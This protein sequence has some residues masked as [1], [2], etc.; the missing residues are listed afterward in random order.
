MQRLRWRLDYCRSLLNNEVK[1]VSTHTMKNK[2]IGIILALLVIG[3]AGVWLVNRYSESES[4]LPPVSDQELTEVSKRAD[5]RAEPPTSAAVTV[6]PSQRVRLAVGSLGFADD[7]ANRQLGDLVVAGLSSVGNLELVERTSLDRALR[8]AEMSLSGLVRPKEAIRVGKLVRADWF[9]LGNTVKVNGTNITVARVVDA[10]NGLMRDVRASTTSQPTKMAD[11][12]AGFVRECRAAAT[13]PKPQVYLAIGAFA[14]VG[15]NSRQA[16]FP[17][18]LRA[19][20][21]RTLPSANLTL[22]ERE[23]VT[24]IL[25]EVRL[26]L[27]GLTESSETN[28]PVKMQSA[29]WLVDGSFQS[30]ETTGFE[31]EVSLRVTRIFGRSTTPQILRGPPGEKLYDEIGSVVRGTLT[32]ASAEAL[33]PT[34][35]SE[36]REQLARGKELFKF[37]TGADDPALFAWHGLNNVASRHQSPDQRRRNL[38]EAAR[39]LEAALL[40]DPTNGETRLYLGASLAD[41]TMSHPEKGLDVLRELAADTQQKRWAMSAGQA[42]GYYYYDANPAEA[43]KWMNVAAANATTERG[44]NQ[45]KEKAAELL[46]KASAGDIEGQRASSEPKTD[47]QEQATLKLLEKRIESAR[48]VMLGKGGVIDDRYGLEPY[49]DSFGEDNKKLAAK[50]LEELLPKLQ[51]R[52]PDMKA[53][54][55][56]AAVSFQVDTNAPMIAEYGKTVSSWGELPEELLDAKGFFN[57]LQSTVYPWCMKFRRFDLALATITA[58]RRAA[59]IRPEVVFTDQDKIRLTYA[60]TKLGRWQEGLEVVETLGDEPV[61]MNGDGPWGGYFD[62]V[63]PNKIANAIRQ[64]INLPIADNGRLEFPHEHKICV[65]YNGAFAIG[66]DAV[67]LAR[68]GQ[69]IKLGFDGRTNDLSKLPIDAWQKISSVEVTGDTVWVGTSGA[70]LIEFD[71]KNKQSRLWTVAEGLLMNEISCLASDAGNLWIGSGRVEGLSARGRSTTPGGLTRMDLKTKKVSSY[72]PSLKTGANAQFTEPPGSI[73]HSL[74][75]GQGLV[76]MDAGDFR[77]YEPRVNAWSKLSADGFSPSKVIFAG[78]QVVAGT[79]IPQCEVTLKPNRETPSTAKDKFVKKQV[80]CAE[81]ERMT[82]DPEISPLIMGKGINAFPAKGG[83][84]VSS[85]AGKTFDSFLSAGEIP[86]PPT[87]LASDGS[88]LYVAGDN[89]IATVDMKQRKLLKTVL[90]SEREVYDLQIA[91]G[92]LWALMYRHLYGAPLSALQ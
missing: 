47:G 3:G 22:L 71:S 55:L 51:Q 65:H 18:Q 54:L 61:K 42:L 24:A 30:Y 12:L 67:W 1:L 44:A 70:G 38:E 84:A 66:P 89:Y 64:R 19:H 57:R 16:Q 20:L 78:D 15:V 26:D 35:R 72:T 41:E 83:L 46:L 31:V 75:A 56:G 86:S 43:A 17:S 87:A 29:F 91:G 60:F 79:R 23:L 59:E 10:R 36:A 90:T 33:V 7:Q 80:S 6:A 73:L 48:S 25:D 69:L 74:V 76:L 81:L 14:D 28:A 52:Y 63:L 62:V 88:H 40:L 8:E 9:L 82:S 32:K 2:I 77:R 39:A 85:N 4:T 27:A 49:V 5:N 11:E 68:E 34:R 53:H 37:T 92:K 13:T 50:R 21:T 58:K 45:F